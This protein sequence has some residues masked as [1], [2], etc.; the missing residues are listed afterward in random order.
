MEL[1]ELPGE[2]Q[3]EPGAFRSFLRGAHLPELL[4]HSLLIGRRA[5]LGKRRP[6]FRRE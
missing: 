4:E 2:G 1:D 3:P 5:M 6:V